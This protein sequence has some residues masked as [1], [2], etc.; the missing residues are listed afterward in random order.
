[1]PSLL[2]EWQDLVLEYGFAFGIGTHALSGK[3][4]LAAISAADSHAA[5]HASG[6][7]RHTLREFLYPLEQMADRCHMEYL[8]P[9][10]LFDSATAAEDHLLDPFLEEWGDLLQALAADKLDLDAASELV[11]LNDGLHSVLGED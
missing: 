10:A 8:P 7:N 6:S 2:R 4:F 9:F 1:M 5:F 3:T 11:T